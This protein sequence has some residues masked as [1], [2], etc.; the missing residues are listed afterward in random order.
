LKPWQ[1]H[2]LQICGLI[3]RARVFPDNI[4]SHTGHHASATQHTARGNCRTSSSTE[5]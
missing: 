3:I 1:I 5:A 4:H 2:I